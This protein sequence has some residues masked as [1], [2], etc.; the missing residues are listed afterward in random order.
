M[1]KVGSAW[2]AGFWHRIRIRRAGW[3]ATI[4]GTMTAP[5]TRVPSVGVE[6]EPPAPAR[7]LLVAASSLLLLAPGLGWGQPLN[8]LKRIGILGNVRPPAGTTNPLQSF[9][10]ALRDIGWSEG[11]TLA[12]EYAL[13]RAALRAVRRARARA[14]RGRCRPDR[15]ERRRDFRARGQAGDPDDPDPR[16]LGCRPG[17]GR[18]GREPRA[19]G[20]QRHRPAR[21]AARLGQVPR[22]GARRRRR[23]D[24][25][26]GDRQPDQRHLRRLRRA[27]RDCGAAARPEAADDPGGAR[28]RA[29]G[30]VRR[31]E[32]R[33]G[34]GAGVRA[35]RRLH[36]QPRADP[37][38]GAR[39]EAAGGRTDPAGGT[40]AARWPRTASICG[41]PRARPRRMP[42][43]CCAASSRPTCRSKQQRASSSSSTGA[44]PARSA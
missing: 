23:R 43:A 1:G 21:A 5:S 26:R 34:R 32:A 20:R 19:A 30:R 24:P 9:I 13:G 8:R 14:G 40:R 4:D 15:R 42:T 38:A 35:G 33:T 29:G 2:L 17:P 12:I 16:A 28:R 37:R 41:R 44:P 10:G 36:Q 11:S 27:E 18:P 6:R 7:R 39:A 31:D 3:P 25:G 22:A